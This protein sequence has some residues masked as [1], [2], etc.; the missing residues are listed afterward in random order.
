MTQEERL[1]VFDDVRKVWVEDLE[2]AI[3]RQKN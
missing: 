1:K 2:K 3:A